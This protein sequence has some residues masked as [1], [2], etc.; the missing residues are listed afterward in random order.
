MS[1][2]EIIRIRRG[3]NIKLQGRADRNFIQVERPFLYALKPPDFTGVLPKIIVKPGDLVKIGTPLFYDKNHPEIKFTAPV[4]GKIAEIT[5]GERRRVLAIVIESDGR[6][7]CL[8]FTKADPSALSREEIL[9]NIIESGMWPVIRQRPY[10]VIADPGDNPKSIFISGFDTSPLAP[11]YD[12]LV[13]DFQNEFQKGIDALRKLTTGKIHLSLNEKT[14][15][16]E[17]YLNVT[18]TEIHFFEGPHPAGNV[19]IQIHHIDPINKGDIVWFVGPLD[20]IRI[21][22]LFLTG[23]IDNSNIVA[24]AGSEINRPGYYKS[25]RGASISPLLKNNLKEGEN[26][27]ISGNVLTG[28]KI[29]KDGYIGFYDNQLTVIPEGKYYDF[30]GWAMPGLKKYSVSRSF[31]S[32]LNPLKEYRLDTN[33]KGGRRSFVLTGEYEKV[34]PMDIH[35]LYLIKAILAEDIDKMEQLG[36]YEVDEEDFALCEFICSSKTDVQAIIRKGLDLMKKEME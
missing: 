25:F 16:V 22:K 21:G 20:V 14:R 28:S 11:E 2:S 15:S 24:V 32:W 36:I 4:S 29:E 33:L 7:D 34:L 30:L 31:F 27:F 12:F 6:D 35:P 17:T 23:Y 5:R 3:L 18:G 13:R 8:Q 26:R 9:S 1:S 10:S 19:G